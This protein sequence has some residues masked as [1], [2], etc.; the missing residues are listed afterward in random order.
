MFLYNALG[1]LVVIRLIIEEVWGDELRFW[2]G[3]GHL[4]AGFEMIL[5]MY[6][7]L[8]FRHFREQLL[9]PPSSFA[10]LQLKHPHPPHTVRPPPVVFQIQ[11]LFLA[12]QVKL[13]YWSEED[14]RDGSEPWSGHPGRPGRGT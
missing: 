1:V 9:R 4:I 2:G 5:A 14:F 12:R 8:K 13:S 3:E 6:P 11:A 7:T 10:E